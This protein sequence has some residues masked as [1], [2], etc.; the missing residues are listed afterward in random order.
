MVE[1]NYKYKFNNGFIAMSDTHAACMNFVNAIETI[2]RIIA[3]QYE[4]RTAKLKADVPQYSKS[5]VAMTWGK[6][7]ELK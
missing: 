7:D 5:I 3:H 2:P 4:E 6:K 1:G